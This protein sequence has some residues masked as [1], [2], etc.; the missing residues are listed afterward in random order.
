MTTKVYISS[1]RMRN[2]PESTWYEDVLCPVCPECGRS[3][4]EVRENTDGTVDLYCKGGH[5]W[6]ITPPLER[7]QDESGVEQ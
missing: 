3:W 7:D 6:T 5:E 1:L 2:E 4:K